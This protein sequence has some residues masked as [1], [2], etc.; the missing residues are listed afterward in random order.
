[1]P[2][3]GTTCRVVRL[4]VIGWREIG[5]AIGAQWIERVR[6]PWPSVSVYVDEEGL[7]LGKPANEHLSGVLYPGVLAGDA[8]LVG[9]AWGP[10]GLDAVSLTRADPAVVAFILSRLGVD[11]ATLTHL[12]GASA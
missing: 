1:M 9:E 8:L 7:S 2:A 11:P 12:E 3:D 5:E 10:D 4:P 6:T